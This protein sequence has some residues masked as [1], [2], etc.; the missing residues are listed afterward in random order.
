LEKKVARNENGSIELTPNERM[1]VSKPMHE[2]ITKILGEFIGGYFL[3]KRIIPQKVSRP[4]GP[5][6]PSDPGP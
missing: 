5:A 2:K 4:K 1:T 6:L 3:I